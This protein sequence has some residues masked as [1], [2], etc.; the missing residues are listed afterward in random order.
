M[1]LVALN[2]PMYYPKYFNFV[3]TPTLANQALGT[4]GYY[5]GL[6]LQA[7]VTDTI[8]KIGFR[9]GTVD[10]TTIDARIETVSAGLPSGT[11]WDTNTNFVQT[12]TAAQDNTFFECTLTAGAA[13]NKG[14]LFA[15]V[16]RTASTAVSGQSHMA[17]VSD[18]G[19]PAFIR[20]STGT[21]VHVPTIGAVMSICYQNA[22]YLPT[23]R[24]IP[25]SGVNTHTFN[26]TSTPDVYGNKIIPPFNCVASGA[27]FTA[28][29]DGNAVVKLYDSDGV[30]VLASA[31]VLST[32]PPTTAAFTNQILFTSSVSLKAG[33]TYYLGVEPSS[34]TNLSLYSFDFTNT[35][36]KKNYA[37]SGCEYVTAKDPSGVGSWTVTTTRALCLSLMISEIDTGP[38]I[39]SGLHPIEQGI[40]A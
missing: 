16:F 23:K 40:S 5:Y 29:M 27:I 34:G 3:G 12:V 6:V 28:D 2:T 33:Q 26:N 1:P 30:T 18:F 25:V 15:I 20:N 9:T 36:I 19:F 17:S 22:G 10:A 4:I 37:D 21:P 8:T 39:N 35:D 7:E 13:V 31:N 38:L 32:Q 14:D 24:S 11:L